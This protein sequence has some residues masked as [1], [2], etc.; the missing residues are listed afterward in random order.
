VLV[1]DDNNSNREILREYLT[2]WGLQPTLA[3]KGD[4][5]MRDL[6]NA[7]SLGCPFPIVLVDA[8]MPNEDGFA[9]VQ[10]IQN[11]AE[12]SSAIVMMLTTAKQLDDAARC[13]ALGVATYLTKPIRQSELL[14]AIM[15]ALGTRPANLD[16]LLEDPLE[17]VFR[18]A[19]PLRVL[20][21]EDNPVN[22]R[23]AVRI[24]EGGDI[25]S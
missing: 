13:R 22:Q 21:A 3:D 1:V 12:L 16:R 20:L 19:R 9:L 24:L 8:T 4:T 18:P 2:H 23:L 11:H 5:A 7:V 15:T 6:W 10:Q 17:P 25:P 14:D